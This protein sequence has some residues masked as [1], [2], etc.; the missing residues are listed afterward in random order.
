MAEAFF[1]LAL[2]NVDGAVRENSEFEFWI[3]V[4]NL[5]WTGHAPRD[6]KEDFPK[7]EGKSLQQYEQELE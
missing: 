1:S 3:R 4:W 2:E 6:A 7:N 5:D